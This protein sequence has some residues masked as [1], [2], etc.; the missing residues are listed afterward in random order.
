[1][2]IKGSLLLLILPFNLPVQAKEKNAT[3][4]SS[5]TVT[6]CSLTIGTDGKKTGMCDV[7]IHFHCT[8]KGQGTFTQ[9]PSTYELILSDPKETWRETLFESPSGKAVPIKN[10]IRDDVD[11]NALVKQL[12]L[13]LYS[14]DFSLPP[15][16]GALKTK[17]TLIFHIAPSSQALPPQEIVPSEKK[18]TT[19]IP[20]PGETDTDADVVSEMPSA[21]DI[22]LSTSFDSHRL[23]VGIIYDPTIFQFIGFR[24]LDQADKVVP[25]TYTGGSSG[26]IDRTG[27][28][29]EIT[30]DYQKPDPKQ[31]IRVA[32]LYTSS[33][34]AK[35]IAIPVE[36][37]LS[38]TAIS[39]PVTVTFSS[40][41]NQ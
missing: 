1:M 32:V 7:S 37:D 41:E 5:I 22:T 24:F 38:P 8:L 35:R 40:P 6:P 2:T 34:H 31:S 3:P 15:A 27:P 10:R 19:T 18:R 39:K 12:N 13:N 23:K 30:S 11:A 14:R 4:L 17:G 20:I 26:P 36:L 16:T 29:Y 28:L 33:T 21:G 9:T 25:M